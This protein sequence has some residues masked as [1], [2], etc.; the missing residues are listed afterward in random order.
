M[1]KSITDR[2]RTNARRD[3]GTKA[4]DSNELLARAAAV[5]TSRTSDIHCS[6]EVPARG[7]ETDVVLG[8]KWGAGAQ[9]V[10]DLKRKCCFEG[11]ARQDVIWVERPALGPMVVEAVSEGLF[12]KEGADVEVDR[13]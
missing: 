4:A 8:T 2:S 12:G 6:D 11:N 10:G 13:R 3:L 7:H 5:I 9:L 1:R